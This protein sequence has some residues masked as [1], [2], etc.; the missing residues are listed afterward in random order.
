VVFD[1]PATGH[2]L[3]MLRSPQ[4]FGTVARVGPIARQ[5]GQVRDLL[6]DPARS[7]Y[8]AVT[9]ATEMGVSETLDLREGLRRELGRELHA[10]VVNG[11]LTRR[12]ESSE[13]QRIAALG[14]D[15]AEGRAVRASNEAISTSDGG[16]PPDAS[17]R[18]TTGR[19]RNVGE[20]GSGRATNGSGSTSGEARKAVAAGG[21]AAMRSAVRAAHTV[22]RRAHTQ[23]AQIARLRRGARSQGST[24]V[25]RV[26]F[27]FRSE[28]DL[29]ALQRIADRL[30]RGL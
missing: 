5:A 24:P 18:A 6:E 16:S 25:L 4:T 27:L 10:V 7:A 9:Q 28:L 29:E 22:H 23:Q 15:P 20:V 14:D 1:A 21:D 2:A 8:L 13:L 30:E 3:A 11:T 12:F 26:P 17:G 19:P